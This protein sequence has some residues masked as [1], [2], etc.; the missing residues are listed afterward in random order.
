MAWWKNGGN[1]HWNASLLLLNNSSP[2]HDSKSPKAVV[3]LW[4]EI[5]FRERENYCAAL[6]K[7]KN[8]LKGRR[9]FYQ[10]WNTTAGSK[11]GRFGTKTLFVSMPVCAR[12]L[13]S[14]LLPF[15][16]LCFLKDHYLFSH[17][18]SNKLLQNC[19]ISITK[20]N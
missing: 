13:P 2:I 10:I 4:G 6:F 17:F 14:F 5:I 12:Y 9:W 19:G 8:N 16:H 20:F 7:T 1:R 3:F 18:D 15:S 11:Y